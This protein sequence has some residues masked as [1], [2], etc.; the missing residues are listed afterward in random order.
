MDRDNHRTIKKSERALALPLPLAWIFAIIG[1]LLPFL[2]IFN[3]G[4]KFGLTSIFGEAGLV[5]MVFILILFLA[6]V[7]VSKISNRL[8]WIV[9]IILFPSIAQIIYLI[10]RKKIIIT[11]SV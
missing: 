2:I 5:I 10:R 7:I 4:G 3:P 9:V 8:L 11:D 1:A 6:D